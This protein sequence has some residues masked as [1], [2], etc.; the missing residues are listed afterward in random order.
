MTADQV[1]AAMPDGPLISRA[2]RSSLRRVVRFMAGAGIRQFL[3]LGSGI[4]TV[5]N[6]HEIAQKAAA[7]ARV[8]YVDVDLVAVI[9]SNAI[10]AG[11]E[12]AAAVQADIR[13][14]AGILTDPTVRSL[15]DFSQPVGVLLLAILH[16]VADQDDPF[17]IVRTLRDAICPGSYLALSHPTAEGS[18]GRR[19]DEVTRVGARSEIGVAIRGRAEITQMFDGLDIVEPGVVFTPEWRPD[20]PDD[21]FND[22][23]ERSVTLLGVGLKR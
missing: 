14:P 3:D 11:N 10:L 17:Q 22:E 21:L 4:P 5:G 7:D 9:H 16:F 1:N 15:I 13:N 20:S 19:L 8:V 18:N 23:P 2:N 12:Q 6:V